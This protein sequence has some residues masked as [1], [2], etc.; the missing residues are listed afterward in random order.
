MKDDVL[1][2][3]EHRNDTYVNVKL[4]L[5]ASKVRLKSDLLAAAGRR[6]AE[7]KWSSK[8]D[9]SN[10]ANKSTMARPMATPSDGKDGQANGIRSEQRREREGKWR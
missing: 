3:F 7:V 9:K 8:K 1:Q 6:G 10:K 4:D 2:F 5:I